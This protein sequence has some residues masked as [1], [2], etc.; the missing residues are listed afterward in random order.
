MAVPYLS[1]AT[2]YELFPFHG[3][4]LADF[5]ASCF[6]QGLGFDQL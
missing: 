1:L 5:F 2:G 4:Y 3:H 6:T